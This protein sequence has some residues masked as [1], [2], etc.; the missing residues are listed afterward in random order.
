MDY[1]LDYEVPAKQK[2]LATTMDYQITN[3]S[4]SQ[5]IQNQADVKE[6]KHTAQPMT[7]GGQK[8]QMADY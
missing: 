7:T 4:L 8:L 5:P 2:D 6:V 1:K 3:S